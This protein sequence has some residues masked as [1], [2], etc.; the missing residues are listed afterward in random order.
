M[1][2]LLIRKHNSY[3]EAFVNYLANTMPQASPT[4]VMVNVIRYPLPEHVTHVYP[5]IR[6]RYDADKIDTSY[7]VCEFE[8]NNET[9]T[10]LRVSSQD[11]KHF[12]DV[13]LPNKNLNAEIIAR[14]KELL[15][16]QVFTAQG[17]Q[18]WPQL[19]EQFLS[20]LKPQE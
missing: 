5:I 7:V 15:P 6:N 13:I 12:A 3:S 1:E 19:R 17:A 2:P 10:M 8:A 16:Q 9:I 4:E 20:Y 14:I 18:D 11:T